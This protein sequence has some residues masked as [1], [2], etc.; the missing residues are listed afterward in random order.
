MDEFLDFSQNISAQPKARTGTEPL[1]EI[2]EGIHDKLSHN[3]VRPKMA[4]KSR[5]FEKPFLFCLFGA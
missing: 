5:N 2:R 4:N 1:G 3:D